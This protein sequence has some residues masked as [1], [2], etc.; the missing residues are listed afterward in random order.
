[1]NNLQKTAIVGALGAAFTAQA[2]THYKGVEL[3]GSELIVKLKA[4]Q[5]KSFLSVK[6]HK[7]MTVKENLNVSF[8]DYMLV[9]VPTNKSMKSAINYLNS[10]PEVEYAEPN[11][12]LSIGSSFEGE[13]GTPRDAEFIKLWGL[14]NKGNNEPTRSGDISTTP[15]KA[16]ADV[17]ALQ[18]WNITKGSRDVTIAV[19]DTGVDYN[20]PDLKNQMWVNEAEAN[21]TEGVDDDGNGFVDD[22]H[23]YDFANNDGDPRDG[24]SHGTHC[25]GTIGAEHNNIG[26]AGVMANVKIVGVKFLTD[27]GSGSTANAIKSVDYATKLNVD[28]MSNSWGG[29]GFSQALKDAISRAKDAGILFV[30]AAGNSSSD[31]DSRP[32]Y[33]SNYDVENVISVAAHNAQDS[34][35]SFSCFG[36]RTVHVAAPGRNIMST[37]KNGGYAVYSGTSMATPHVSGVLGLLLAKEG[38]SDVSDIRERLMKSSV[39]VASYKKK[40]ISEGR[41]DAYNLLTNTFPARPAKPDPNAWVTRRLRSVIESAHPYGDNATQEFEVSAEGA[42]YMRVVFE[43]IELE[44][45]YDFIE[46]RDREGNLVEKISGTKNNYQSEYV[47]GGY[48]KLIFKSDRS[49]SKWGFKA[50]EY[51]VINN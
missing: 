31:N 42:K 20:H 26:V 4:G 13:E 47:S 17:N 9:N 34:L 1:M 27:S 30:A 8:G 43:K 32:H 10:L 2:A 29:G 25:A 44:N 18:A 7:G 51:Q 14:Q 23:G 49:V 48:M 50:S 3:A 21:G 39:Y 15:G 35:A 46:I 22:I 24:H 40:T 6:S 45:K 38:R 12:K 33:P 28:I 16:G 5:A 37:V 19:I 11:Y 41:V 36:K